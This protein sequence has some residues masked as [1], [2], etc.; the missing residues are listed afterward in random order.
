MPECWWFAK[1]GY[2]SAGDECLYAHPKERRVECPDY[3]RGFC[4]L[5]TSFASAQ[6]VTADVLKVPHVPVNTFGASH[7][8]CT[9]QDTVLEVPIAP[10]ASK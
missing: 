10:R 4:K 3:K 2:C 7:V 8:S 6:W 5:G 1:Y 9:S